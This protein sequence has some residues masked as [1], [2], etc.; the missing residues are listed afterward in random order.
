[1]NAL[2]EGCDG[3]LVVEGSID[4][5]THFK[6]YCVVN[7][8][9][10]NVVIGRADSDININHPVISRKHARL[11]SDGEFMTLSDLGSSS[12][13]F[14]KGVPCLQGEVMFIET[15]DVIFLADVRI[16]FNVIK[17]QGELS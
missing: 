12:G 5:D 7:T 11:E 4:T 6:R 10:I 15:E 13:T 16:R 8:G 14:I 3:V 2:P 9:Q 1:M 17:K